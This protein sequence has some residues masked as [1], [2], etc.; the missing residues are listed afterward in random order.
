MTRWENLQ[1]LTFEEND[2]KNDR[3]PTKAMADKVEQCW[4]PKGITYDMLPDI[5][6]GWTTPFRQ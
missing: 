2:E 6:D 1:M 4:W 5:Y 3:L